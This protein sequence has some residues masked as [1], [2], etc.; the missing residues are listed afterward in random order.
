MKRN[1]KAWPVFSANAF[2][3]QINPQPPYQ[4]G[5]VWSVSHQQLFIDSML[6]GYDIP[7]LY[8]REVNTD[9]YK[10]EII[11]GQQ[12]LKAIWDFFAGEFSLPRDSDPISGVPVAG[13][14]YV[15]L[16]IDLSNLINLYQLDVVII[17]EATDDDIED[18]FLRFQNGVPL[19]SAEKRHAISGGLR[20][21]V[22]N[23]AETHSFTSESLGFAN[24]RF[25]HEEILAQM[26][27][28]EKEQGPTRL[29][30]TQLKALYEE[31][32]KFQANA[33]EAKQLK[34]VLG[35]LRRAFP[36]RNPDLN[37]V[38]T[39]SLYTL[40]TATID[41]YVLKD[42]EQ[43]FR[44]WF[45]DFQNRREED[46]QRS[47]DERDTTLMSYQ[48]AVSGQSSDVASQE[49]RHRILLE[50]MTT[51]I[52]DLKQQ[53]GQRIFR[54]EQRAAIF[55]LAHGKCAN[56]FGNPDCDIRCRADNFHADHINPHSKGGLTTVDNGQLLC[57]SCNLKKGSKA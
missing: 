6:K 23:L 4:R 39:I 45:D 21:F 40:V 56:P 22:Q 55:R 46:D 48:Y 20:D 41:R 31:N 57:P 53:D 11:D 30:H 52:P 7:K 37:K 19:N 27:L 54:P 1:T 33:L 43:D 36:D 12:R 8:L 44:N 38:N 3:E 35:F 17:D 29:R 16:P 24:K 2:K 49:T 15:E 51:Q 47:E 14:S 9:G 10:W 18:M 13:L 28:I 32:K 26:L 5:S 25:A 42:R 50:D 34:R